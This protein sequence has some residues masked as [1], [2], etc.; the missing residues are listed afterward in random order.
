MHALESL[1]FCI[2]VELELIISNIDYM[3]NRFDTL[4]V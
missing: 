1:W 3:L 2:K 4:T